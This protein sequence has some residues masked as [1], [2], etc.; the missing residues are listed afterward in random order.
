M[1]YARLVEIPD[2]ESADEPAETNPS[3]TDDRLDPVRLG[4]KV[5][6]YGKRLSFLVARKPPGSD[7]TGDD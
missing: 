1:L 6:D 7:A 4:N 3:M 5:F 2:D